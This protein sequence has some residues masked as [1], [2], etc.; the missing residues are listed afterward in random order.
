MIDSASIA[1]PG[2]TV[3]VGDRPVPILK[4]STAGEIAFQN[5]LARRA[6][7]ALGS[8]GYFERSR[9]ALEYLKANKLYGEFELAVKHI[10][11]MEAG[12]S[13][14][15]GEAIDAFRQCAD[16][17]A[18]ELFWRTRKSCPDMK[19]EEIAAVITET[20]ALDV[21]LQ[22]LEVLTDGHKST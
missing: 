16:G 5:D 14:P 17:V 8:G 9:D 11:G 22:I 21:H 1:S 13:L 18:V 19:L 12:G 20:N 4:L 15:S 6:K 7:K 2:G 3:Y 10:A